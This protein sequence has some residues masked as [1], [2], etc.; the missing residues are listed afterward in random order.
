MQAPTPRPDDAAAPPP[1]APDGAELAA[2][3]AELDTVDDALHDLLMRRYAI[4]ARLAE[5][6]AKGDGPALRPGRE[7]Q[8]LRRLLARHAGPLSHG[9]LV[10]IW[11]EVLAA[12]TALQGPFTVAAVHAP[13]ARHLAREHFGAATPIRTHATPAQALAAVAAGEASVAV[14]PAP[15][16]DESVETAWWPRLD[17]PRLQVVARLPFWAPGNGGGG[18]AEALVVSRIPADPTGRD[19]T[20]LAI[21]DAAERSRARLAA[22][23]AG[24]GLAPRML[25]PLRRDGAA[26][27]ALAEVEGFL[28][29][30]DP[31]LAALPFARAQILGAYAVPETGE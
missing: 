30:D 15:A 13:A 28:E 3:R 23:L 27:P 5:S 9:A 19:R 17:A 6:R 29:P 22:M 7:A 26:T 10:R 11:R 18:G 8:I 1:P 2:L 20:L 4:V 16:E 25:L 14:L 31:R 24:A 12:S 21:E